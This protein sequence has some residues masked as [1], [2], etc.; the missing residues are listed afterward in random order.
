[1]KESYEKGL[2]NR[3]APNP[4]LTTVTS[5]VWHGQGVH[6]GRVLSVDWSPKSPLSRAHAVLTV[7]GNTRHDASWQVVPRHGGVLDPVQV[8]KLQTREP[9]D[10]IGFRRA[11]W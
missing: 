10:P 11:A 4:T 1:M 9:G 8:W 5:W 6:A 3:S 2:A 7:E